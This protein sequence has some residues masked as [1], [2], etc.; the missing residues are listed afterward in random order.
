MPIPDP[1]RQDRIREIGPWS[2]LA[3]HCAVLA[4]LIL[5]GRQAWHVR[6]A[7]ERGGSRATVLYWSNSVGSG[8]ARARVHGSEKVH[9]AAHTVQKTIA[10]LP[11]EKTLDQT[12]AA[13]TE[14]ANASPA[15]S[16]APHPSLT[17]E[18]TGTDNATP[19]FPIYSPTPPVDRSLLPRSDENVVVD[20]SV[21]SLGEVLDERLVHGLGNGIDQVILDTVKNWKFHP[22][23]VN[24]NPIDSVSEL[25]FPLSQRYHG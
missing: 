22:A 18:G 6:P 11:L 12:P 2:S 19:A 1:A 17:G 24:G 14:N 13:T 7:T 23:T 16:T 20:V 25:V 9:P 10:R 5:A 21:S 15:G 3:A 4:V 8:I